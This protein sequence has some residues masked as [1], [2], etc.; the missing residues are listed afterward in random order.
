MSCDCVTQCIANAIAGGT[1]NALTIPLLPCA[2]GTN[3]LILT[4]SATNSGA[5]T[6][7][8][9]GYPAIPIQ[10]V[11]GTALVSGMLVSGSVV[12]LTCTGTAWRMLLAVPL[13]TPLTPANGGTGISSYTIG[14]ILYASGSSTL[15]KLADAATGNALISGG[16]GVTP[17]YGKIGLTTH[18]S[19]IL[20][21]ANGGTGGATGAAASPLLSLVYTVGQANT[22]TSAQTGDTAEHKLT[23]VAIP[24]GLLGTNGSLRVTV[25]G[26]HTGG[27]SGAVTFYVRF[28][29]ANDLTGQQ[30]GSTTVSS[31][32][33]S[34]GIV[35]LMS[36]RN[37]AS[38]QAA[39]VIS[40]QGASCA[41][42]A[43]GPWAI[44]TAGAT[45][46]V[47][48]GQSTNAADSYT[49]DQVVVEFLPSGGN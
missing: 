4:L 12:L 9:A 24:A 22:T 1:A 49:A 32:Q 21:K 23:S 15:S 36:N 29:T 5:A 46:V 39:L 44:N 3:I 35:T 28:G 34:A 37:S 13:T 38:A 27:G 43:F 31:G 8:M 2:L 25:Q 18:V 10:D 45:F 14:D 41:G 20:P 7:Q 33:T 6:L 26:N 16:V 42:S 40:L 47:I 19:G 11:T 30:I 48:S 17:S